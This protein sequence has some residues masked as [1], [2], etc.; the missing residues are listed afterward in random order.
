MKNNLLSILILLSLNCASNKCF[1]NQSIN[2]KLLTGSGVKHWNISPSINGYIK[3]E[4]WLFRENGTF[5]YYDYST[6]KRDGNIEIVEWFGNDIKVGENGVIPWI[7]KSNTLEIARIKYRILKLEKDT[8]IVEY[9]QSIYGLR[10]TLVFT[11]C[12]ECSKK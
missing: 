5:S 9:P 11:Y 4:C 2:A 7:L 10:D 3:E 1:K 6:Y 12:K 8:L